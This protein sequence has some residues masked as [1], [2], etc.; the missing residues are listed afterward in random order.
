MATLHVTTPR[1]CLCS[2]CLC[3]RNTLTLQP[4]KVTAATVTGLRC[5]AGASSSDITPV[6]SLHFVER[7]TGMGMLLQCELGPSA[8]KWVTPGYPAM[9]H[10][11]FSLEFRRRANVDDDIAGIKHAATAKYVPFATRHCA[12]SPPLRLFTPIVCCM[13]WLQFPDMFFHADVVKLNV[14]NVVPSD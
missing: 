2:T 6:R 5:M 7:Y 1:R 4:P 11:K 3:C 8:A 10:V 14:G 9:A 13:G 12:Y